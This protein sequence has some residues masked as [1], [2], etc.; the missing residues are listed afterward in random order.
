MAGDKGMNYER[1]GV[2]VLCDIDW[3]R[4]HVVSFIL[5]ILLQMIDIK[6]TREE[7]T[8]YYNSMWKDE[9]MYEIMR[10]FQN[11]LQEIRLSK[12]YTNTQNNA[13]DGLNSVLYMAEKEFT[14][15]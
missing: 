11:I 6:K 3:L 10:D 15:F 4:L 5:H 8:K 13:L 14:D 1:R 9:K 12:K 7:L 2:F